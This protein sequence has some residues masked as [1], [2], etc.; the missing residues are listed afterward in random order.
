MADVDN[1]VIEEWRDIEGYE[2][3]YMVSSLGRIKSLNYHKTGTERILK[4][5]RS[6][7]G[8]LFVRLSKNGKVKNCNIHKLAAEAFIPNP[9]S[10]TEINHKDED[11]YNNSIDNLEWCDHT[12]NIT[13]GTRNDRVADKLS[14]TVLQYTIDDKLVKEWP[15]IMEIERKLGFRRGNISYC[16]QGKIKTAYGYKWKHKNSL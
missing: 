16:C 1:K 15:S 3:Q 5:Q 12:Y 10:L 8:Y 13:Y 7:N 4:P 14:K 11:K 2:R 6:T 9:D